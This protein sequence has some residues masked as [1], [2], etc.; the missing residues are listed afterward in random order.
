MNERPALR[1][2][3]PIVEPNEWEQVTEQPSVAA[4]G[5]ELLVGLCKLS[6]HCWLREQA[7]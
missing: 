3:L 1:I 6:A 5:G 7:P 4:T 2:L